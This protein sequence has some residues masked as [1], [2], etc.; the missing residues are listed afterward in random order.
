MEAPLT[1]KMPQSDR[2]LLTQPTED[3]RSYFHFPTEGAPNGT[4]EDYYCTR[5]EMDD[6]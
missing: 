2:L 3:T 1:N 4:D 6:D 5:E